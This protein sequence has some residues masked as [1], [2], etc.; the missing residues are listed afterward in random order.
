MSSRNRLFGMLRGAPEFAVSTV[1]TAD[2]DLIPCT[3]VPTRVVPGPP[4]ADTWLR[5]STLP[6]PAERLFARCVQSDGHDAK[7]VPLCIDLSQSDVS[8]R[9]NARGALGVDD[10]FEVGTDHARVRAVKG[11]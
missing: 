3:S 6:H 4:F 10:R 9:P 1:L 5:R 11:D 2:H 7:W 8:S